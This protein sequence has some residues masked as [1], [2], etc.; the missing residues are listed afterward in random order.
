[1]WVE[2]NGPGIPKSEH[3]SI[4]DKYTRLHAKEGPKGIGLGLAYCRLA[5]E[6]HHGRI[7]V[8][9]NPGEGSRFT[10]TLPLTAESE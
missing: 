6:G 4:F 5:V 9:S 7:W 3:E 1:M 2:D 8:E 10:F